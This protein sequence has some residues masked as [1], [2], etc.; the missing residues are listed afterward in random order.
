MASSAPACRFTKN[1]F[2]QC[3]I[4]ILLAITRLSPDLSSLHNLI[5]ACPPIAHAFRKNGPEIVDSVMR[6]SLPMQIQAIIHIIVLIR[7]SSLASPSLDEFIQ[8][9]APPTASPNIPTS[10]SKATSLVIL[11]G[12]LTSAYQIWLLTHACL[13]YYI[14]QCMAHQLSHL[15]DSTSTVEIIGN[16][17]KSGADEE[18]RESPMYN[19]SIQG[20]RYQLHSSGPPSEVEEQ[21]VARAFW[22]VQ[23]LYDLQ[24]AAESQLGWPEEDLNRLRDMD[25]EQLASV[26]HVEPEQVPR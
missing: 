16:S 1:P 3:P 15:A 13:Q 19:A 5:Q 12:I 11:H 21:R 25:G 20:R 26:L 17:L 18:W 7:S 24:N 9:Y 23:M 10:L 14:N 2:E 4:E 6:I 22:L 8:V